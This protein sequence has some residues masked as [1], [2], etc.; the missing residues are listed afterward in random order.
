MLAS[1]H[2]YERLPPGGQNKRGSTFYA[3]FVEY[4]EPVSSLVLLS[5]PETDGSEHWSRLGFQGF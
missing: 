4:P 5:V 1:P 2:A 3:A